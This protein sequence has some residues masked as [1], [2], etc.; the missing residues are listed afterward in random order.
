MQKRDWAKVKEL[1][2]EYS[3][4]KYTKLTPEEKLAI[5]EDMYR[6]ALKVASEKV[7]YPWPG[8][9]NW[10]QIPHLKYL[11]ETRKKLLKLVSPPNDNR[12]A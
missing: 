1:E 7:L 4:E 9:K 8:D 10:E 11:I 3:R 2:S 5:Y 6:Y 12:G